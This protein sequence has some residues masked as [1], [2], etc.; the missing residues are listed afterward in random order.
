MEKNTVEVAE[1]YGESIYTKRWE[2]LCNSHCYRK[3]VVR[4]LI[5]ITTKT[6]YMVIFLPSETTYWFGQQWDKKN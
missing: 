2:L 3:N 1:V 4:F 6:L 5:Q